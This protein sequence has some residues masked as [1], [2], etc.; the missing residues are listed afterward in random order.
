M[1][2]IWKGYR[3]IRSCFTVLITGMFTKVKLGKPY[4]LMTLS[5]D[6][7][8]DPALKQ[9]DYVVSSGEWRIPMII[10]KEYRALLTVSN[11]DGNWKVV[12]LGATSLAK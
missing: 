11:V 8:T 5:E 12:G 6:F 4:Q 7:F 10:D 2:P 1:L 3:W 9:K